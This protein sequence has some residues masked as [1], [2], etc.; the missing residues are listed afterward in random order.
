MGNTTTSG[1]DNPDET[2]NMFNSDGTICDTD[3]MNQATLTELKQN[4]ETAQTTLANAPSQLETAKKNYYTFV[5]GTSGYNKTQ[6]SELTVKA[7]TIA[8]TLQNNFNKSYNDIVT[9]LQ[10]YQG[11]YINFDNII[12]LLKTYLQENNE[13]KKEIKMISTDIVT[14]DRKTYYEDQS[15]HGLK[16]YYEWMKY[17]YIFLLIVYLFCIF[18]IP[19]Q[20]SRKTEIIIFLLLVV[21]PFIIN[22]IWK[23]VLNTYNKILSLLPKNVYKTLGPIGLLEIK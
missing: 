9:L 17:I 10:T 21:Y 4:Y 19:P 20:M 16:R 18:L 15:I 23:F 12:E 1:T 6:Q 14:N 2:L 13:L 11:T 8:T 5:D 22:P 7:E 3:C